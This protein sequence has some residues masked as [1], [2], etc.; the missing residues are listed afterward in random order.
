MG[1]I[2]RKRW[3]GKYYHAETQAYDWQAQWQPA[4]DQRQP[5]HQQNQQTQAEQQG[6]VD[7]NDVPPHFVLHNWIRGG[8]TACCCQYDQRLRSHGTNAAQC[9]SAT[10][11]RA[12]FMAFVNF[13]PPPVLSISVNSTT[14]QCFQC[15]FQCNGQARNAG[16][17]FV[18]QQSEWRRHDIISLSRSAGTGVR[19]K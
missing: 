15:S 9:S 13:R 11:R 8:G 10:L 4:Q 17:T 2:I 5:C 3:P 1:R 6:A 19:L 14:F 7:R 16:Q 12:I 18:S